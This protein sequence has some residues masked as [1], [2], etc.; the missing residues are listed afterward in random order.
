MTWDSRHNRRRQAL[1][2]HET[3]RS[4]LDHLVYPFTGP[5][6]LVTTWI[7]RET[8]LRQG[9]G[10]VSM[11]CVGTSKT[12]INNKKSFGTLCQRVPAKVCLAYGVTN[13]GMRMMYGCVDER[14]KRGKKDAI[15]MIIVVRSGANRSTTSSL[16]QGVLFFASISSHTSKTAPT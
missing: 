6:P 5:H 11:D 3:H 7:V 16:F 8:R 12:G 10:L 2:H 9:K 15:Y 1:H 4:H 14:G 13:D